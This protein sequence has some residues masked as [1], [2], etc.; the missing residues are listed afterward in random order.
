V[1]GFWT[2]QLKPIE[3]A[4]MQR[5]DGCQRVILEP[6]WSAWTEIPSLSTLYN[7]MVDFFSTSRHCT[8]EVLEM[9][10]RCTGIC[11]RVYDLFFPRTWLVILYS[12]MVVMSMYP[13]KELLITQTCKSLQSFSSWYVNPEVSGSSPGPVDFS[14]PIS[15]KHSWID[16][17]RGAGIA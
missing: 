3:G 4:L 5:Q 8:F 7:W 15:L 10:W 14:E 11:W 12:L 2:V 9:G 17:W 1:Y 13:F 6:Q 16:L